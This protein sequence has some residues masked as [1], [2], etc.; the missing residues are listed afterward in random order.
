MRLLAPPEYAAVA[1]G[2]ERPGRVAGPVRIARSG[3]LSGRRAD[4]A[5]ALIARVL[6][7]SPEV[8]VG[9]G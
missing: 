3:Q 6:R 8:Q 9:N 2:D 5:R 4:V 1:I 7:V